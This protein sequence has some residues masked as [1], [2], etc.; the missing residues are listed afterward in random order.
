MTGGGRSQILTMSGGAGGVYI[1][2]HVSRREYA[3]VH[4]KSSMNLVTVRI[5]TLLC[6]NLS[7]VSMCE[8]DGDDIN[9]TK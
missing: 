4:I 9:S 3:N 1:D 7:E 2:I 5:E 6:G 8:A